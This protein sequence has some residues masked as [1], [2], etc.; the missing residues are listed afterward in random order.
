MSIRCTQ[1][2]HRNQQIIGC[3]IDTNCSD[4]SPYCNSCLPSHGQH[5]KKLM[6]LELLNEWIQQK[7]L[8]V[9]NVQMN[10]QECKGS[11]DSLLDMLIPYLN[12]NTQQFSEIG[13]SQI[14]LMMKGLCS[15]ESCEVQLFEQLKCAIQQIKFIIDEIV[16]KMKN[17]RNYKE[18]CSFQ[19][20]AQLD[21]PFSNRTPMRQGRIERNVSQSTFEL[22]GQNSIKQQD[23]CYAIA[24][25]KDNSIV[26]VGCD[27]DIKVFEHQYGKLNQI[28]LLSEHINSVFT[29]NFMNKTNKFLSG[30]VD[31]SIRIWQMVGY[32][33]W[34]C[35]QKLKAHS[36]SIFCVLLNSTD[37]LIITCSFDT[38]I[39]FW[40]KNQQWICEQ[41]ITDNTNPVNSLSLNEKQD[42]LIS[43]SSDS[44][45]V[46]EQCKQD[47]KWSVSQ[48]INLFGQRLCFIN[49]NQFTFQPYC[50]EQMQV[51]NFDT[52]RQEYRM[53]KEIVVN[54]GSNNDDVLFP[55]QYLKSKCLL[56]NKNG[57]NVNLLRKKE[58]GD[59]IIQQSI[60]FGTHNI[61][62]QLS[63]D[64]EYLITW[65][66]ES[67]EIQIR[68][69]REL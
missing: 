38:T 18:K 57:K 3:C 15:L 64:G 50:K 30:S 25:N 14:N 62:G 16:K 31:S 32:N 48:K 39:K 61:Y 60:Q 2:D 40:I 59:F 69:F 12:C 1:A 65:D 43:S 54:C 13:L 45:L 66:T 7:I 29:L 4:Q 37:D 11:L 19:N 46:I 23:R 68:K 34:N 24:F 33:Q 51:Y 47:R 56:V 41:T 36:A 42:K 21:F 8:K 52:Q 67:K 49:D 6:S 27:K 35:Q 5:L 9:K 17:N 28:Q 44:I 55:Q 10:V 58:N 53:T 26:L 22:I 63:N 20:P